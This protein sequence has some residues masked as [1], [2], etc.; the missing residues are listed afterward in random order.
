MYQF[1][2]GISAPVL[3][4]L[5]ISCGGGG[6]EQ[7]STGDP[8][9]PPP[10]SDTPDIANGQREFEQQCSDCHALTDPTMIKSYSVSGIADAIETGMPLNNASQCDA[11]CSRDIAAYLAQFN[12]SLNSGGSSS[13][14][15]SG[16][17]EGLGE[18]NIPSGA[19]D[20]APIVAQRLTR[21]EYN[22][23]VQDLF[24]TDLSPADEFPEDDFA[25]GFNNVGSVLSVS[26]AHTE[27][28]KK[29]VDQLVNEAILKALGPLSETFG[30][31]ALTINDQ[32]SLTNDGSVF[33]CCNSAE[34]SVTVLSLIHI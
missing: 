23:T 34:A 4:T 25:F 20:A 30:A 2:K 26:L 27:Q 6:T 33:F 22:N 14:S 19:I 9:T 3:I 29:A 10:T 1:I 18:I 11:A 28:Y 5:L 21:V 12:D 24:Y 32:A 8:S 15:S 13:S 17:T 7:G 31:D 16:A